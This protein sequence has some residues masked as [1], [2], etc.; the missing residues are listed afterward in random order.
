MEILTQ[1]CVLSEVPAGSGSALCLCLALLK[2][3]NKNFF[4]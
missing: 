2:K 4:N 1:F 3:K